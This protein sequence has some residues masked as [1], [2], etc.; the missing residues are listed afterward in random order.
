VLHS[1]WGRG[2]IDLPPGIA[3]KLLTTPV[4]VSGDILD[5][6]GRKDLRRSM[7]VERVSDNARNQKFKVKDERQQPLQVD[8][9]R[10]QETERINVEDKH[11][12]KKAQQ[13]VRQLEQQP[14]KETRT[15][16]PTQKN[17]KRKAAP[18]PHGEQ[19]GNPAKQQ[20]KG[21]A[22]Q[23]RK[24]TSSGGGQVPKTSDKA[25]AKPKGNGKGKP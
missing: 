23:E 17:A 9:A 16:Q 3:K 2:K 21:A 7:R 18:Q 10:K 25:K 15:Q 13:E 22:K 6:P 19:V 14:K 11:G 4:Y 1:A 8:Q 24:P 20:S 12:A 5:S